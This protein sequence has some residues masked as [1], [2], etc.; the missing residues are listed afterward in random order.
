MRFGE[1]IEIFLN[2]LHVL[3]KTF[4]PIVLRPLPIINV[5]RGVFAKAKSYKLVT[6]SGIFKE[7]RPVLANASSPI[8]VTELPIVR[9]VSVHTSLK[10]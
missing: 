10:A 9:S 6:L 2:E 3:S 4:R 1:L 7:V 8:D 5:S